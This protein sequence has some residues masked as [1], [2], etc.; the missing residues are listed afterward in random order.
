[1]A[2][3]SGRPPGLCW[4]ATEDK[5]ERLYVDDVLL[6]SVDGGGLGGFGRRLASGWKVLSS[7]FVHQGRTLVEAWLRRRA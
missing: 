6:G 3:K 4:H 5:G 2:D 7:D 1:M